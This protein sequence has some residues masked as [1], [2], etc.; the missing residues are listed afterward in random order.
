MT[1][2]PAFKKI[3]V[4]CRF[5]TSSDPAWEDA[6]KEIERGSEDYFADYYGYIIAIA[7]TGIRCEILNGRYGNYNFGSEGHYILVLEGGLVFKNLGRYDEGY[8]EERMRLVQYV[9]TGVDPGAANDVVTDPDDIV[10]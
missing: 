10:F 1:M 6:L 7:D 9:T 3:R 5:R 2:L 4:T 8:Q